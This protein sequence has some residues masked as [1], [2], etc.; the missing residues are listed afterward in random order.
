MFG[1]LAICSV[2]PPWAPPDFESKCSFNFR[3][4]TMCSLTDRGKPQKRRAS[5]VFSGVVL[6]LVEKVCRALS[7]ALL[8][9]LAVLQRAGAS[10][11]GDWLLSFSEYR[12]SQT[13]RRAYHPCVY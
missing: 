5:F 2:S 1:L 12:M 7:D 4:G 8:V 10:S 6:A 11:R 9:N 3:Y 13:L